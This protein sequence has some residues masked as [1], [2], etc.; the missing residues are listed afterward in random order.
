MRSLITWILLLL[1]SST[2]SQPVLTITDARKA[3]PVAA[4]AYYLEDLTHKLTV[5]QVSRYPLDSF[6][7]LNHPEVVQLGFRQ[8]TIWLRFT[9]ENQT[10]AD[11]YLISSYRRYEQLDVFLVDKG[12]V[13]NRF[14]AG[15]AEPFRNKLIPSATP[16]VRLGPNPKT[17]YLRIFVGPNAYGDYLH[18]GDIGQA[19]LYNRDFIRWQN[20]ALGAYLVVF[21]FGLVLY[22]RLR[23]SLLGWYTLLMA[24]ILLFYVDFYGYIVE[25]VEYAYWQKTIPTVAIYQLC[26]SVF[27]LKFLNLKAYSRFL[28]WSVLGLNMLFWV[29]YP[30]TFI[31]ELINGEPFNLLGYLLHWARLDWGHWILVVLLTLFISLIYVSIQN[32]NG[33]RGYALAFIISLGSMIISMFALYELPWLP[34]VPYNNA[35]VPGTLIEILILGYIL[36]ERASRERRQQAITQQQLIAQLQENIRQ[37]DKLLRIRDEIAR[38]LHDE[39]GATLTSIAISTKL[40]QKKVNGQQPDIQPILDQIKAD[41]EDTIHSIR[42]TVWTLNPDNDAPA[43]FLERL[44]TVAVQM[45]NNAGILLDFACDVAADTLPPF[46]MEQRRNLYLVYKEAL[47]N[48]VKHAQA[49]Q[50]RIQ[51]SRE[52]GQLRILVAD[53]GRGFDRTVQSD[54]NGLA[55]FRKRAAE[56]GFSV[57]VRSLEGAGTAVEM[58]VP[59]READAVII[60]QQTAL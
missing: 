20:L 44:R 29:G 41:S 18:L 9:V 51:I 46:P 22:L 8:G 49:S 7:R 43:R 19:Y 52:S 37:R 35:F 32:F 3:N 13:V 11:L 38:D 59:V 16:I 10:Q 17:V 27:H 1:S 54:G 31:N 26:W 23:D 42:D 24:S 56:G 21:L 28:Y 55:N 2:F 5:E 53:N 36:A 33:I 39:V 12:K 25:F 34:H 14:Q 15:H 6:K 57:Q 4:H 47:H 58:R 48:I 40:V 50:V 60:N 30:L 45:L